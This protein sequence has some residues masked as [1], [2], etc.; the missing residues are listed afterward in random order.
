MKSFLAGGPRL[1]KD[2]YQDSEKRGISESTLKRAKKRLAVVSY[3]YQQSWWWKLPSD[4][5][6]LPEGADLQHEAFEGTE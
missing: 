5:T 1:A 2:G 6:P 4:T 3:K